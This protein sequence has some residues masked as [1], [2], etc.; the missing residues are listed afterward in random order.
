MSNAAGAS[1][2]SGMS[3]PVFTITT[4]TR[5]RPEAIARMVQSV[6]EH[7]GVP[8]ELLIADASDRQGTLHFLDPRVRVI[9]EPA[10]LGPPRGFNVLFRQ[11][12]GLWVIYLSD[13]LELPRGWGPA[14]LAATQRN[15][16]VDLFVLPV[17]ERGDSE[18]MLLLYHGMP[19]A[20]FGCLRREAGRALGWFDED[21]SFYATDPDLA[22]RLIK[23]GR[24]LAPARGAHVFHHR[25]ADEERVHNQLAFERDNARLSSIWRSQHRAQLR[26]YRRTSFRYFRDLETR[27]SEVWESKALAVPTDARPPSQPPLKRHRVRA[28]F[29]WLGI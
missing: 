3:E 22:M 29:W 7:T 15:P 10:R 14:L 27:W 21:Y 18:A 26:R 4:G 13:D 24:R 12:R 17:V 1:Y 16:E 23:A 8:F 20:C 2:E 19:Y 11:A 5:N 28:P 6:V 25:L 9:P